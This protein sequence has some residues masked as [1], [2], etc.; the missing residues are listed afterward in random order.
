MAVHSRLAVQDNHLLK[1]QK[2][3]LYLEGEGITIFHVF[4]KSLNPSILHL[5]HYSNALETMTKYLFSEYTDISKLVGKL[6]HH[7]LRHCFE[8]SPLKNCFFRTWG[9]KLKDTFPSLTKHKKN[10]KGREQK[11]F[12]W[13]KRCS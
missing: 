8:D 13:I 7:R 12:C 2:M 3:I 6:S 1:N 11:I 10:I 4:V 9:S 5:L